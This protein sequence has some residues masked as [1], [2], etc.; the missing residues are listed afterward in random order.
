MLAWIEMIMLSIFLGACGVVVV[1]S[2][3]Q[4]FKRIH[5]STEKRDFQYKIGYKTSHG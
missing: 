3:Y 1:T 4:L 2:C 5:R